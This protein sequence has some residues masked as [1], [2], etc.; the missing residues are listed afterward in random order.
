M[1]HETTLPQA[2]RLPR[3]SNVT[4]AFLEASCRAD[5]LTEWRVY[6]GDKSLCFFIF[7]L[8]S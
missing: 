5:P 1:T 4:L 8:R 6:D 7:G 3:I 2:E